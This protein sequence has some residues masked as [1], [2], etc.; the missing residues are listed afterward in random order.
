MYGPTMFLYQLLLWR[1]NKYSVLRVVV[2]KRYINDKT[3]DATVCI[4]YLPSASVINFLFLRFSRVGYYVLQTLCELPGA[5]TG[6]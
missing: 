5:N 6:V 2:Q 4:V 3:E 1:R